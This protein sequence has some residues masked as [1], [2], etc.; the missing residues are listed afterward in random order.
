MFRSAHGVRIRTEHAAVAGLRLEQLSAARAAVEVLA[1]VLRHRLLSLDATQ[2]ACDRCLGSEHKVS[3]TTY[4]PATLSAGAD[5]AGGTASYEPPRAK[6]QPRRE[7]WNYDNCPSVHHIPTSGASG[8]CVRSKESGILTDAI[9]RACSAG[10]NFGGR[11]TLISVH[12]HDLPGRSGGKSTRSS[13][14]TSAHSG[15]RGSSANWMVCFTS[16]RLVGLL[17]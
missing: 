1:G 15:Y 10:A 13:P 3:L 11:L 8:C 2:G 4:T 17:K 12:A 5:T 14:R 9:W 6:G 7:A 16:I